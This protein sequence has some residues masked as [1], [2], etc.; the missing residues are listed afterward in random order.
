MVTAA[1][2]VETTIGRVVAEIVRGRVNADPDGAMV[3]IKDFR[4]DEV[5]AA[6]QQLLGW[7]L[8]DGRRVDIH[9]VSHREVPS[10]P[11]SVILPPDASATTF[12]NADRQTVAARVFFELDPYSDRQSLGRL[13]TIDDQSVIGGDPTRLALIVQH[14]WSD[15]LLIPALTNR[16]LRI[17]ESCVSASHVAGDG[18]VVPLRRWVSFIGEVCGALSSLGRAV[19]DSDVDSAVGRL[20]PALD[21]LPDDDLQAVR[22]DHQRV[23][24]FTRNALYARKR[25]RAGRA[26]DA[27]VL[28]E[29]ATQCVFS[30]GE[31][32]LDSSARFEVAK[33]IAQRLNGAAHS[34][35]LYRYWDQLF[36]PKSRRRGLGQ[37]VQMFLEERYPDRLAE[38]SDDVL[39]A[40]DQADSREAQRFAE[41]SNGE[42]GPSLYELLDPVLARAVDKIAHPSSR[43]AVDPLRDIARE[44]YEMIAEADESLTD[45]CIVIRPEDRLDEGGKRSLDLFMFLFGRT[46]FESVSDGTSVRVELELP[47]AQSS[48]EQIWPSARQDSESGFAEDGWAWSA[49]RLAFHWRGES[50]IDRRLEWRPNTDHGYSSFARLIALPNEVRW[51]TNELHIDDWLERIATGPMSPPGAT[52]VPADDGPTARWLSLRAETFGGWSRGLAAT[53]LDRY[54]EAWAKLL[55]KVTTDYVPQGVPHPEVARFLAVDTF[56]SR[57][58]GRPDFAVLGTHP[59]KL[60]W[61]AAHLRHLG[62]LLRKI[63]DGECL[64]AEVND[65]FFFERLALAS[66]HD[67][68]PILAA[69][70]ALHVAVREVGPHEI[71]ARIREATRDTRDWLSDVDSESIDEIA[72]TVEAYT[73]AYP[74]TSDGL[75][76]LVV[77]QRGGAHLLGQLVRHVRRRG[78]RR[79][80]LR[81]TVIAPRESFS[82]I[83]AVLLEFDDADDRSSSDFPRLD[84]T[85]APWDNLNELPTEHNIPGEQHR[86][87][88]AIV[89]NLFGAFTRPREG[90]RNRPE[91]MQFDPWRDQP[92]D[93]R[94]PDEVDTPQASRALLPERRDDILERW[95]TLCIRHFRGQAVGEVGPD[96]VDFLTL[97]VPID[98]G[99]R[100]FD[101]L[102]LRAR[103]VIT[104]DEFVGRDQIEALPARPDVISVKTG[105]G[106]ADAYTL[107]VSSHDGKSFVTERL[108]RRLR[109]YV[110]NL[111]PSWTELAREVYERAR[112]LAPGLLLRAAGL[113]RSTQELVGL[114]VARW[115]T[116]RNFPFRADDRVLEGW[117]PL[118]EHTDWFG[119]STNRADFL[120]LAAW[121][122]NGRLKVQ[123]WVVEAKLRDSWADS[124]A[125]LQVK[126]TIALFRHALMSQRPEPEDAPFWRRAVLSALEQ[127]SKQQPRARLQGHVPPAFMA[128][129]AGRRRARVSPDARDAWLEGNFDLCSLEGVV[130]SMR[131]EDAPPPES[132]R[133][134]EGFHWLKLAREDM[135]FALQEMMGEAQADSSAVGLVASI[136]SLVPASVTPNA[137]G[138]DG[139]IGAPSPSPSTPGS[140]TADTA[141]PDPSVA[142]PRV[143]LEK[144]YQRVLS[145][146]Q[147]F[148]VK[149]HR[150]AT[151]PYREGPGFFVFR[152]EPGVGVR[153]DVVRK[154]VEEIKLKLGLPAEY[155]PRSYV[156]RGA[157]VFEIPKSDDER[158]FVD[159]ELMWSE[160]APSQ[161]RLYA[162]LGRDIRGEIVGLDFSSSDSPHLL[163]GG[164]TGSGKSVALETLL[165]GLVRQWGPDRL[166]LLLVDPKGTELMMF[167]DDPHLEMPIGMGA[168]DAIDVLRRA[169]DEMERRRFIFREARVRSLPEYNERCE[170]DRLPW[171]LIVLDEYADLTSDRDERKEIEQLLQRVCQKAR[172][173]GIHVIVATQKPSQEVISTTIRSNLPAQLAL[174]VKTASDSRV[175]MDEAGAESLAGKGDAFLKTVRG[176]TRLQCA[177][178]PNR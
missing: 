26:V 56:E 127:S 101:E 27:D 165:H 23:R 154:L 140:L 25:D 86:F 69:G 53:E 163:I 61:F 157:V 106:A 174:R 133:T 105:V 161:G 41:E 34:T 48:F 135:A 33:G 99:N 35:V 83:E 44:L 20:L 124:H 136:N 166:R 114:V 82:D 66:A 131:P 54:V 164:T 19:D 111:G 115:V 50:R 137:A 89:P 146:F 145:V 97:Q 117:I 64:L 2:S 75:A 65:S 132:E 107:V 36:S 102:H 122:D 71:F 120:R 128:W 1:P 74:H 88:L 13:D 6:I 169:V 85:L 63:V 59:A 81:L 177:S 159:A 5:A 57:A 148:S 38:F 15:G 40:L 144:R 151:E 14:T 52:P 58:K 68:P 104:L 45:R 118:D 24:R 43:L 78:E 42:E 7:R 119:A 149:V 141:L 138:Q 162:P 143:D 100:F 176:V 11:L 31:V 72:R 156:D 155:L 147:E 73:E 77:L 125:N 76:L 79:S 46:L 32:E 8:T 93:L 49:L 62:R 28:A 29:S 84:V 116:A 139:V 134:A 113:G 91:G 130:C 168:E 39:D 158:Y 9:V 170:H 70:E 98:R 110:P 171:W 3:L 121:W 37:R 80:T 92:T 95:S 4:R 17:Y 160:S 152:V 30:D 109:A 22:T 126:T 60:R 172:A 150:P 87:D 18:T 67:Q 10:I 94:T 129:E 55:E 167:D 47:S 103:W 173:S 175:I 153:P 142:S 108:E 21:L 90:T 112:V 51:V 178:V 16:L 96:M 12:R 123:G